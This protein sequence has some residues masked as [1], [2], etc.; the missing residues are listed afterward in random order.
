MVGPNISETLVLIQTPFLVIFA[1]IQYNQLEC[2]LNSID[3]RT[4]VSGIHKLFKKKQYKYNT[5]LAYN[6][7]LPKEVIDLFF[8]EI[9]STI[10]AISEASDI[11]NPN[12]STTDYPWAFMPFD[13][14]ELSKLHI[15]HNE[16]SSCT[17]LGVRQSIILLSI[18]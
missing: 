17:S 18:I 4:G 13:L 2:K 8:K 6:S 16:L 3:E 9:Y 10:F 1:I 15:V 14:V 7:Q 5:P 11:K 12:L